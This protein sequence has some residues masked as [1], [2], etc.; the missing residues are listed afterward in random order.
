MKL[1]NNNNCDLTTLPVSRQDI[2]RH[3]V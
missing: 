2:C 1:S 3:S